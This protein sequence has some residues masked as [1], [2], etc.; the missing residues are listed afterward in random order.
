[1]TR[2]IDFFASRKCGFDFHLIRRGR[3]GHWFDV[4]WCCGCEA[5]LAIAGRNLFCISL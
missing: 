1:M 5:G 4:W 3:F 2:H